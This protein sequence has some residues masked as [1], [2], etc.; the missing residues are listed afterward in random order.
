M[1]T[2]AYRK[3]IP[4]KYRD[5]VYNFILRDILFFKRN[6]KTIAR[7]KFSYWFHFIIPRTSTN[8]AFVFMGKYGICILPYDFTLKY[9]PL[10]I[11]QYTD[12]SNQ[13]TYVIHN[14]KK[15]Y[16]PRNLKSADVDKMYK[17]LLAEQDE[18]S[19]HR[20]VKYWE[21]LSGKTLL[22]IGAAEGFIALNVIDIV[23]HVFLFECD[24]NWVE[25]L[26][27]TFAPYKNKV[28][29]IKKY[30]SHINDDCNLTMDHFFQGKMINNLF[31]KMDI[32]GAELSAL[33]GA[34]KILTDSKDLLLAICTYH[35]K[36]DFKKISH[37]LSEKGL[38]CD[39][40]EGR[41]FLH[42]EFRIGVI[43]A[44]N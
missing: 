36:D 8:N 16:F 21:E 12:E 42:N 34:T 37:L 6:F 25:A 26:N 7:A 40:T 2:N 39:S 29:I 18:S 38:Y 35:G 27:A 23:E 31:I 3:Y 1:I 30:I 28:T 4:E 44:K 10:N 43:R 24:E 33:Q 20:Y 41:I 14:H 22:D 13:L 17:Q 9:K 32:E 5:F 15:L 11:I 19:P